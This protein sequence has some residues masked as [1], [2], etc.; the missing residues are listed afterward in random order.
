GR[1]ERAARHLEGATR[2]EVW[3]VG[4][5]EHRTGRHP[6]RLPPRRTGHAPVPTRGRRRRSEAS[7]TATVFSDMGAITRER[8]LLG[9]RKSPV[10]LW[11]GA[12]SLVPSTRNSA[13]GGIVMKRTLIGGAVA[14]VAFLL[15]GSI[16]AVASSDPC[17]FKSTMYSDGASSCQSG[18]QYKC[19]DGEWKSR[20]IACADSPVKLSRAC[21]FGGVSYSTGSARW[22]P[23]MQFF[24][25]GGG[26]AAAG[27]H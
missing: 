24:C 1:E 14:A 2:P 18:T 20:G 10:R 11:H 26:W 21:D 3:R 15:L 12:C 9:G 22:Q 27:E 19:D 7:Q 17:F 5:G 23:G 6:A 8:V 25:E 16:H 13:K 4:G